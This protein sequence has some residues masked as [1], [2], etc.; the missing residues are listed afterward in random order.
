MRALAVCFLLA[1][2]VFAQVPRIG[3]IDYYGIRRVPEN[4]IAKALGVREG[5]P[6][7]A[8]KGDIEEKLE[9]IPGV[10]QAR[11]E[12]V[13]CD[14]GRAILYVGIEER[15]ALHFDYRDPPHGDATLPEGAL[16]AYHE[17]LTA[18]ER[19][20]RAGN[21]G[22]SLA[23][24]H[25][26]AADPQARA[27]QTKLAAIASAHL[28][29]IRQVLRDAT[30]PEQRAAAA[31]IL[32]YAP[33]RRTVVDDLQYGMQDADQDVRANAMRSLAAVAALAARNRDLGIRVEPTWFIEMLNSIVWS[34]RERA[35]QALVSITENRN[36]YALA[37]MRERALNALIE[38]ARWKTLAHAVA[39]FILLGR[40]AG[41]PEAKIHEYWS[42][43]DREIVIR[44]AMRK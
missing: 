8:S 41:L 12:A 39:P 17:F 40:V 24:G 7:P 1:P 11:L 13:C 29:S 34:D 23:Q 9:T 19:A 42:K 6:L 44:L 35:A 14:G 25:F 28:D 2:A 43:G 4:R 32:G 18:F 22:E 21:T 3:V 30:D 33:L 16:D 38:M 26:F 37:Q 20:A 5:D 31:Y 15:G 27:W 10:V 36:P